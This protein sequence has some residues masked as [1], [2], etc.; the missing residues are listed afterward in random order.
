MAVDIQFLVGFHHLGGLNGVEIAYLSQSRVVFGIFLLQL[1]KPVGGHVHHV[2][3]LVLDVGNLFLD[4]GD[5][6]VGLV[7][8]E[9]QDALHLDFHQ[10]QDVVL[11]HFAY[12]LR[13]EGRQPFVD[14][15]ASCVH[16]GGILEGLAFVDAL[17]NENL[18]QRAEV[19]LFQQ[20]VAAY[21]QF[22]AQQ[23]HRVVHVVAQHIADGEEF[24]RVVFDD[25]AVGRDVVL[26]VAEGIEGVDGLVGAHTGSQVYLYLHLSRREVFHVAHLDLAFVYGFQNAVDERLCGLA[27]RYFSDDERLRVKFF[28]LRPHLQHAATH[29]VVVFAHVNATARGEIGIEL[30]GFSLQIAHGSVADLAHVVGQDLRRQ[31]YGDAFGTLC[32]E[33]RELRGQGD[34]LFV[35]AVV[36][37][38]PFRGLRVEHHVE[39]EFRQAGLD[40]SWRSSPAARQDVAPVALAV[41]EQFFLAHLHQGITDGGIAVGVELHRVAHNVG[42]L[43]EPAV[44]HALHR[45]Q[46]AALHGLQTIIDVR[47]GT[48][49]DYIRGIVEKPGLVHTAQM[50]H[51]RGIKSVH[52]L[53]VGV[54]VCVELVGELYVFHLVVHIL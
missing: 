44:V 30:E 10:S 28:Y 26:A 42:H 17:L 24:R 38:L 3:Q 51:G 47:H 46:D 35:A 8:A 48:L 39:G 31:T 53:V 41:D 20:F 19:Q 9:F 45:V 6:L 13:V 25:A 27:E 7:L 37:H 16:R 5:E 14:I 23:V 33:Q 34:G 18:F 21:L 11:S 22:L 15:F 32:Q 43:V 36:R 50:V 29:A 40:I 54:A 49:Q 2:V 4:A 52:R 1:H 12:H